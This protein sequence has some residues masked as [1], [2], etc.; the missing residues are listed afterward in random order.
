MTR[1]SVDE[2]ALELAKVVARRATCLRRAVGCVLLDRWHH[3]LA[4]GYNG[5]A[6]GQP[7]CN[8]AV[9]TG[10][11][12]TQARDSPVFNPRPTYPHACVG[13]NA[14]SG[15]NLDYCQAIH[16]EQNAL[17]Q[18]REPQA[19]ITCYVTTAPCV[20]C[21]KLLLGTSCQRIVF[22]EPY[23][24]PEAAALWYQAGRKWDSAYVVK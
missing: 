1:P 22:I 15:K 14:A 3:V 17:V 13:A 23:A 11:R 12:L 18:C 10:G 16:A 6:A 24:Q 9:L 20:G 21:V 4:T 5:V 2:W 7:H 8:E 19:V